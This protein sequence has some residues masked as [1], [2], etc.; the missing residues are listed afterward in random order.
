MSEVSEKVE[1]PVVVEEA[2]VSTAEAAPVAPVESAHHDH[3]WDF[4]AAMKHHN[5]PYPSWEILHGKPLIV[6]QPEY[7][8]KKNN[9]TMEEVHDAAIIGVMPKGL[10]WVNQQTFFGTSALLIMFL[11][12]GVLGRRKA[13]QL[14]PVGV[15]QGMI[16]SVVV[17]IRDNI[18]RPN[19]HHGD[20]WTPYFTAVFLAVL[21]FNLKG[22]IPGTGTASGNP[23][24]TAGF[25][26]VTLFVMLFAG[27]KEQ[28]VGAF[29]KNLVPVHFSFK[30]MDLFLWV[31]LA[32]IEVVG[33]IMKP[34]ALAIRLF[35]NMFAGHTLL[36]AFT[37]LGFIL[38][39]QD[40]HHALTLG[41]GAF[42]FVFA[43]AINFLELLVAFIQAFVFTLL[44]AV[45]I[46]ACIH[47]EH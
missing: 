6:F 22:M 36:L 38:H 16:E 31:L 32:I 44:S 2:P 9:M 42:G 3:K 26:A 39:A 25:A 35:A 10:Q 4:L 13:D 27:M 14:K 11:V 19:V 40:S 17:Y 20:N 12:V 8:A 28:G 18:V 47:P 1:S 34:A 46:G 21:A 41:L 30:P 24:V 15:L 5:L 43:I 45:F 23:G 37:A 7:Y 29:W 33:L